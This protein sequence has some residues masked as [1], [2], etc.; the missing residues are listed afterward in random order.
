MGKIR[1]VVAGVGN[2]CSALVQGLQYYREN[3]PCLGLTNEMLGSYGVDDIEIVA[4]F[5]IDDR[6]VGIDLSEAI[7]QEPNNAPRFTDV[8]DLGVIVD[9]GSALDDIEEDSMSQINRSMVDPVDLVDVLRGTG[10]EIFLNLI[11]G[12]SDKAA[13]LYADACLE[14]GVGFINATPIEI[15]GDPE[16]VDRFERNGSPIAGDD[17]L[18]QI[19]AT[20][21]HIGIIELLSLRGVRV[22]ESYQL[23]VGGGT[24]S[25]DTL[26]KSREVKR[27]IKTD[28][29]SKAA[30]YEFPIVSGS[31]D[32]VDFLGNVRDSFFW[33]KGRY[34]CGAPFSLDL[35]LSTIDSANGGAVLIDVVRGV[36]IAM[37][38]G[39]RGLVEPVCSYGFKSGER[40]SMVDTLRV[41]REF[42]EGR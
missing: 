28:A 16:W 10:S 36:K 15:A 7:F 11:S 14:S 41:F 2:L 8:P 31:T 21:L 24:E 18:D 17:L 3:K 1:V 23:D 19:G 37:D 26:E 6:K 40:T 32:F 35:K 9:M 29:V 39:L 27:S 33:V 4:A 42:S 20:A 12:G 22:D 34:F 38:R 5:D 25:I 30:P 13:R